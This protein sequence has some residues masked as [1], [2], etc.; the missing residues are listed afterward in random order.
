[1]YSVQ[2]VL[3]NVQCIYVSSTLVVAVVFLQS[4]TASQFF[5]WTQR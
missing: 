3:N 1:M 4:A 2:Y 5:L